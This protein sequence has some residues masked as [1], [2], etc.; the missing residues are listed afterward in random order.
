[1]KRRLFFGIIL[2]LLLS[3]TAS[4]AWLFFKTTPHPHY[5]RLQTGDIVFQDTGGAQGAAVTAATQSPF[6]HCGIVFEQAGKLYVFEAIQP[7]KVVTLDSWKA[8]SKVFHAKRLKNRSKLN[9]EAINRAVIWAEEQLGKNYDFKFQWSDD[10]LYCSELVWKIYHHATGITLCPPQR[11]SN[12]NLNDQAVLNIITQRYGNP[13]NLPQDELVVA[14]SDLAN[15][16]LLVEAPRRR[17]KHQS[18]R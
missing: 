6:T 3:L 5:E 4:H 12:Y 13:Q 11:F 7:V 9:Q 1:M 18:S 17:K 16:P 8:R 2:I 15:S 14:P 10:S